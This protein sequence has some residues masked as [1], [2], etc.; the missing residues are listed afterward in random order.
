MLNAKSPS[1]LCADVLRSEIEDGFTNPPKLASTA[2]R[3]F[4]GQV[5]RGHRDGALGRGVGLAPD[6]LHSRE[7][8]NETCKSIQ[9][10]YS[11]NWSLKL[12]FLKQIPKIVLEGEGEPEMLERTLR[13]HILQ[14]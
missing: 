3:A 10:I 1:G 5:D 6:L 9:V 4:S 7:D 13:C 12:C 8:H 2:R 14:S 11:E